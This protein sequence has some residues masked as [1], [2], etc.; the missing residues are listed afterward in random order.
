MNVNSVVRAAALT[1]LLVGLTMLG[2]SMLERA[3]ARQPDVAHGHQIALTYCSRCHAVEPGKTSTVPDAPPFYTLGQHF[4]VEDLAEALAEG[5]MVGHE[6]VQM[7]EFQLEPDDIDDFIAYLK[8]IQQPATP[9]P[10]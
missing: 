1:A 10:R 2:S 3:Q 6:G 7:P 4:P 5:I 8:T 9:A